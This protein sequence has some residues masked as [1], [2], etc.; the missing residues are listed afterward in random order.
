LPPLIE[1]HDVS[2][3]RGL[4]LVLD[5]VTLSV[6][7]GEHLAVLGPNGSGKSTL[8]QA[9]TRE[10][11]PLQRGGGSYLRILGREDWDLFELRGLLGIVSNDLMQTC[12]RDY[13]VAET[14]LSGFFGSVGIWPHHHVTAAME[15]RVREVLELLEIERLADRPVDELSSGEARRALIGRALVHAP[16]ALVLDEPT[17]SLD[18]RAAHGLREILRKIARAGTS[19]IVATHHLPDILPEVERVACLRG[20]RLL[21]DGPKHEILTPQCLAELF[22][23]PVEIARRDGYYHAW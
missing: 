15:Q 22:G 14:L 12:T 4:S 16:K 17:N 11:Y 20:G 23:V 8:I 10:C 1:F 6:G 3:A 2:V 9:M 19:L 5:C 18:L 21:R 7:L 13:S